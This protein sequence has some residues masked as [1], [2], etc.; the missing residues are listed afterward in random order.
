MRKTILIHSLLTILIVTAF[1]VLF[2]RHTLIWAEGVSFFSFA[3]DFTGLQ[4]R[5]PEDIF[6]YCG[7][8]LLQFFR[9]PIVGAL[10]LALMV[11][12][13]VI[14]F[15][16]AVYRLTHKP[17]LSSMS[18]VPAAAM[19]AMLPRGLT[20]ERPL[21]WCSLA[22][23]VA[24][25]AWAAGYLPALRILK[26][27]KSGG[28]VCIVIIPTVL[29]VIGCIYAA[30]NPEYRMYERLYKLEHLAEAKDWDT[31]LE[32]I[33]PEDSATDHIDRR[34]ALLALFSKG[35]LADNM[36]SYGITSA[37]DL[38]FPNTDEA[39]AQY[40]NALFYGELGFDNETLHQMYQGNN[41]TRFGMSNRALR[42]IAET[43]IRQGNADLAEKFL[44]ILNST[45]LHGKW[46]KSRVRELE[47][48]SMNVCKKDPKDGTV[49]VRLKSPTP[50]I[51]DVGRMVSAYPTNKKYADLLLCGLL[52]SR[53]LDKFYKVFRILAPNVYPVATTKHP[54]IIQEALLLC[55]FTYPDIV[56]YAKF[57][58]YNADAYNDFIGMMNRGEKMKAMSKYPNSYW[59]YFYQK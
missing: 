50:L 33:S 44:I 55:S 48:K 54:R 29:L 53:E 20:L 59:K 2:F 10:I 26:T 12:V 32:E 57:D 49:P 52:A 14:C 22:I 39:E 27:G 8:F 43:Y 30:R 24:L 7:A 31:I 58:K 41:Q 46:V 21:I 25:L 51:S 37:D 35:I 56:N 15:D 3:P 34:F 18:F 17:W 13:V 23:F 28:I 45:P 42:R 4:M 5:V 38:I 9:W 47:A 16:I 6:A 19:I 36:L 11:L 1:W 40:F